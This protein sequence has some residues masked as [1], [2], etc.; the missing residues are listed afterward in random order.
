[1]TPAESIQQDVLPM[2]YRGLDCDDPKIHELCLSVLPTFAGLLDHSNVKNH[3]LPRIKKLCLGTNSLSVR[4]NCLL[5]IG[6]LLENLDKWLV[7]DEVLPFMPQITSREPAVLMGI[8][9]IYK[10]TLT[11]KKL[12]ISKEIIASRILP[13]LMPLC[14]ENSLSLPQFNALITLVKEMLNVVENEHRTKLEQLNAVKDQQKI[15]TSTMPTPV[16]E[17]KSPDLG[18]AFNGLGLDS[19]ASSQSMSEPVKKVEASDVF[20]DFNK[21]VAV[22]N[23]S[24]EVKIE[25]GVKM[26]V[27][28]PIKSSTSFENKVNVSQNTIN[29]SF[30][31]NNSWSQNNNFASPVNKQ[32]NLV[33]PTSQFN[34]ATN[35]QNQQYG[36]TS[37][38]NYNMQSA[39]IMQQFGTS[40]QNKN[41]TDTNSFSNFQSNQFDKKATQTN[42]SALDNLLPQS[43]SNQKIPLNQMMSNTPLLPTNVNTNGNLSNRNN[44]AALS[45]DEIMDLL[46]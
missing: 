39:G 13:F 12:G 26:P 1:M 21:S 31:S 46:S 42:W 5:C 32:L 17:K 41:V 10:L 34:S 7:M 15:L 9:G 27:L 36:L 45:K 24:R 40:N 30:G 28:Q 43:N 16:A 14:I 4:V 25:N 22:K 29:T 33:S 11:H 20:T 3:L 6:G 44:N 2:L 37:P 8:L 23:V 35:I 19:Y 18:Q 38:M